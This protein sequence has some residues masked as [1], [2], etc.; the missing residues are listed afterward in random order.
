MTTRGD[1]LIFRWHLEP[2]KRKPSLYPA[3]ELRRQLHPDPQH[4]LAVSCLK[5]GVEVVKAVAVDAA[6][7][8]RS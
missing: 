1:G 8:V 2:R 7:G 6:A 3:R 4:L 5:A